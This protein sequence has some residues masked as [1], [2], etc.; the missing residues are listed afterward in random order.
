MTGA[1]ALLGSGEFTEALLETD[2]FL[3]TQIENPKVAIVP[4][5]AGL[6]DTVDSWIND[7][8]AHF[9]KLD[10]P[11]KGVRLLNSEDAHSKQTLEQLKDSNFFYFSGGDPGYLLDTIR[12]SPAWQYI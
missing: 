12:D 3:L 11:A 4:T 5:A 2:K 9:K 1:L 7:G 10:I 6:E 8:I